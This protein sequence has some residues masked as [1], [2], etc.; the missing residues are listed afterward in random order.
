LARY[1]EQLTEDKAK[2]ERRLVNARK[3]IDLLGLE[4]ERWQKAVEQM[5]ADFEKVEGDVFVATAS[6]SYFGPFSGGYRDQL[7]AQWLQICSEHGVPASERYSLVKTLSDPVTIRSWNLCG[8]PSDS[9][10]V[11][12]GILATKSKMA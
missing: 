8:L 7:V 6:V 1:V 4:G 9:V 3:L 10:S 5:Q 2:Y 12:N 11:D